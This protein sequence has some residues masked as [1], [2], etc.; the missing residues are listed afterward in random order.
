MK[1]ESAMELLSG[2]PEHGDAGARRAATEHAAACRDCRD[3]LGAL[4]TLRAAALAVV[5]P[6]RAGAYERAIGAATRTPV[7]AARR[8]RTFWAGMGVGAA[9][10]AGIAF[11]I[12][13]LG[14]VS[15]PE[16]LTTAPQLSLA[17]NEMRNVS[18]VVNS[19]ET[20]ADAEVHVVLSGPIDLRGYEGRRELRWRTDLESGPNQLTLPVVATGDGGGQLLVE[21]LH[22]GKRRTFIVDISARS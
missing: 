22:L 9:L 15:R 18:I 17:V 21:I 12:V 7:V 5:P 19:P 20:L 4:H 16:S 8:S 10:A 3:A 2:S 14:P 11:A 6:P 1:C 13:T